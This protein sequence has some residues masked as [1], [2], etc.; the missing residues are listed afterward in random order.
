MRR[1]GRCA[2]MQASVIAHFKFLV[3]HRA[4][5]VGWKVVH[6]VEGLQTRD[7]VVRA[8]TADVIH[9]M[10]IQGKIVICRYQQS[11]E[12]HNGVV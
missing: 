2:I 5:P 3:T 10:K 6:V 4:S 7:G 1:A 8:Y 12:F 11:M 9:R